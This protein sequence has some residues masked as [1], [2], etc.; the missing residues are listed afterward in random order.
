MHGIA[1][2]QV[3]DQALLENPS[4]ERN[5]PLCD[6]ARI[7]DGVDKFDGGDIRKC[8][9]CSKQKNL[10]RKR[11]PKLNVHHYVR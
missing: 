8:V 5:P 4:T 6:S 9:R 11:V 10:I 7:V 3:P 2:I 1:P